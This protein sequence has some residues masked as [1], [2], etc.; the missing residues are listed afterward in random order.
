MDWDEPQQTKA[1][2]VHRDLTDVSI[3]LVEDYIGQL[4][5]EIQRAQADIAA[6]Q[7]ARSAADSAFK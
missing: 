3:E 5:A 6:K 4:E 7:V 1:P 2:V